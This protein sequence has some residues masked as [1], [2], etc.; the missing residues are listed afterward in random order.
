M[1]ISEEFEHKEQSQ[2]SAKNLNSEKQPYFNNLPEMLQNNDDTE[3]DIKSPNVGC[4]PENSNEESPMCIVSP[5]NQQDRILV[6]TDYINGTSYVA[7]N[8]AS[9]KDETQSLHQS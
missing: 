5:D 1:I 7:S 4:I 6:N 3:E 2:A 9:Q 8:I